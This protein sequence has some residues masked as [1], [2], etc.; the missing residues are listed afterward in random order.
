MTLLY[1]AVESKKLDVRIV[2]RNL[3]RGAVSIAELEKSLNNLPDDSENAEWVTLES[4]QD[5]ATTA[6]SA[7]QH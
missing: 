4:L 2:E 6:N 3:T 1:E 5:E 7:P